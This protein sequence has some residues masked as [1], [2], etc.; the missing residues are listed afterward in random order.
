MG[1]RS[2]SLSAFDALRTASA[3]G[4]SAS[5]SLLTSGFLF[6]SR[7]HS[8]NRYT[9]YEGSGESLA[10]HRAT[11]ALQQPLQ[12]VGQTVGAGAPRPDPIQQYDQAMTAPAAQAAVSNAAA[13]SASNQP[14]GGM[15]D[16]D[17][18][19][20]N[21]AA[22]RGPKSIPRGSQEHFKNIH[23]SKSAQDGMV[24]L[25]FPFFREQLRR[26]LFSGC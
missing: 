18:Q 8:A 9:P 10:Q 24:Y 23:A 20:L 3:T 1:G 17:Q 6:N 4:V 19:L 22:S 12:R 11:V 13:P 15:A 14:S 7:A 25:L 2:D 5:S 26:V 16:E 21:G